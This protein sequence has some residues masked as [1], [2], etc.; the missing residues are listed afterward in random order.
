MIFSVS[1]IPARA[2]SVVSGYLH[3]APSLRTVGL[4]GGGG[5]NGGAAKLEG[6]VT[7]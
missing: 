5:V 7:C 2:S 6:G 4:S 1:I 3:R